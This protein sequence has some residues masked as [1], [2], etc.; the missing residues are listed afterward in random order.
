[1]KRLVLILLAALVLISGCDIMPEKEPGY[2]VNIP[3]EK[4]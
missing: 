4:V 3:L 1:M 2:E